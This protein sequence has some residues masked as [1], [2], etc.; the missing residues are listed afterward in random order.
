MSS[1]KRERGDLLNKVSDKQCF[2]KQG[3]AIHSLKGGEKKLT[4]CP[5]ERRQVYK[6]G[7][8]WED[9]L[10]HERNDIRET[11][12]QKNLRRKQR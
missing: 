2:T 10:F 9:L 7:S 5:E 8:R 12:K 1:D 3:K 6:R 4:G 11:K